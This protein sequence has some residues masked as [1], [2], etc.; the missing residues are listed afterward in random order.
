MATRNIKD[1]KD[2]STNELIYFKGHAQA[3]FMSDGR[4]VE[5]AINNVSGSGSSSE[6]IRY[7]TEFTVDEFKEA[8][9]NES[10]ISSNGLYNA[11]INNKLI[12]VPNGDAG[13]VIASVW[14]NDS[15]GFSE[16]EIEIESYSITYRLTHSYD[17]TFW[18]VLPISSRLLVE[19]LASPIESGYYKDNKIYVIKNTVNALVV[20]SEDVSYYGITICFTTG[21]DPVL[22]FGS[23]VLW[24]NGV[25][26]EIEANTT[27]ELS[28]RRS[29]NSNVSAVLVP[30]KSL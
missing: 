16:S 29:D 26:P 1:A 20:Y 9:E 22:E 24:P 17:D 25:I 3:T 13:Y 18:G 2:L 28:L 15:L 23:D 10:E 4:T 6:D 27:Y 8:C 5:E 14:S 30:F 19:Q 12:C 11:I 21:D 7:F